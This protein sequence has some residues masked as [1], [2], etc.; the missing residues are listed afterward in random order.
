MWEK[1]KKGGKRSGSLQEDLKDIQLTN[2]VCMQGEGI[3]PADPQMQEESRP[4]F[5][6]VDL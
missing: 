5:I 3:L 2:A 1:G 6:K 4:N